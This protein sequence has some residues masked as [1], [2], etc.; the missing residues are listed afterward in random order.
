MPISY[1][2]IILCYALMLVAC[3]Q[4][5]NQQQ[6]QSQIDELKRKADAAYKPGLGEFMSEIQVHHEKLWFAGKNENWKLADFE[7]HEIMESLQGIQLYA[8][9]REESKKVVMLSPA[10]DSVNNA[11]EQKD[12]AKF[13]SGFVLLTNTCNKCHVAVNYEFNMVKI[14]ETPPFSNQVFKAGDN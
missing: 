5:N 2:S 13:V 7:I 6:L 9:E 1:S 11:I 10:L 3:N 4:N 8:A 14:P 12:T